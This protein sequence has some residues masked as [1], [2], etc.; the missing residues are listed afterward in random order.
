MTGARFQRPVRTGGVNGYKTDNE[1]PLLSPSTS[2]KRQCRQSKRW[3]SS[4]CKYLCP[5]LENS[6]LPQKITLTE[7][8]PPRHAGNA[9]SALRDPITVTSTLHYWKQVVFFETLTNELPRLADVLLR[10]WRVTRDGPPA[11]EWQGRRRSTFP[12]QGPSCVEPSHGELQDQKPWPCRG[13]C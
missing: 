11:E 2:A 10:S 9:L 5:V 1:T 4:I 7:S 6:H 3:D 12:R 8:T 13:P